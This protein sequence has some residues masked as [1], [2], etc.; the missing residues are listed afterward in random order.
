MNSRKDL[1]SELRAIQERLGAAQGKQYWRSLEEL[2][3]TPAFQELMQREFPDQASEWPDGLSRRQFLTLMGASLALAGLSGCSVRPAPQREIVPYVR[4]PEEMVPGKPLF[5]ATTMTLGG[6]ATG[7]LVES[8]MGRPTKVEGNPDHP[9]SRGATDVFA[10]ASVLTLYDPD[11]SQTV[12]LLG[13]TRTWDDAYTALRTALSKLENGAGLRVLTESVISPTLADQLGQLLDKYPEAR[14]H[15]HEPVDR[16]AARAGAQL[17]YGK[18]VD[19]HYDFNHADVILSLDDD[20]LGCGPG[21]LRYVADFMARRRVR[22]GTTDADRATMNRLYVVETSVTSTGAKADHRLA[23]R[24]GEIEAFARALAVELKVPGAPTAPRLSQAAL[25]WLRHVADDLR[26]LDPRPGQNRTQPRP[27]GTTLVV[28]GNRQPAAVHLLAHALNDYLGNVGKTVFHTA[29]VEVLERSKSLKDLEEDMREGKVKLLVILGGNPAYTTPADFSFVDLMSRV[30][31]RFH[32][33]LYQDETSRQCQWHLP[34]AHYLEA[35]SDARAYEGT[36][37]IVQPLIQPLY[38]GR[39]AHEV[40]SVL[41]QGRETPGYETVRAYWR[42]QL[43][44]RSQSTPFEELWQ[45]ALHDGVIAGTK[46]PSLPVSLR[47]G[48]A[49]DAVPAGPHRAGRR[50]IVFR[51]DPTLYDGR[52]ANNGWLQ[53]LPKPLTKLTWDNAALMSPKT[54]RELGVRELKTNSKGGP[55]GGTYTEVVEL[56]LHGWKVRAPVWIMPGHAD[57]SVTVYLGHGRKYAGRVGNGTGF[58]AY[59]LRPSDQLWFSSGLGVDRTRDTQLLACT[60]HHQLMENR[61]LVRS[62]TLKAYR[63]NPRFAAEP[64]EKLERQLTEVA[65]KPLDMYDGKE[66]NPSPAQRWAMA[67]DLTACTGC[68]A[69]VV[70]CQAENNIPVVGKDQVTRGREMHW[71]RIDTYHGSGHHEPEVPTE[72]HFQ[73]VPCMQCEAAPCEYVCPV[74]ATVHSADGLNDMVYNRCVGTRFCSNNCPYKVRRFNF[75]QFADYATESL[76]LMRNPDV[77]VRSR[78]VMEKCTYCVQRIRY[79]VI[80]AEKEERPVRDGEILTACQAACPAQA[81]LFGDLSHEDSAVARWK[82]SPLN[83]SLL[84]ELNTLPRTTYL[85]ALRNANPEMEA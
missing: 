76:K 61:A 79:A 32:L 22:T 52:F 11:R 20:F 55:H 46:F 2:A 25:S 19:T 3:D 24:A 59:A 4:A 69:C 16:E 60:Q 26:Y 72:F 9:A 48:W 35:W 13:R 30:P 82:K 77:T 66:P 73:P 63:K 44:A 15:R 58:N 42:K 64:E 27:R 80:E 75:F 65:R 68:S 36:A 83:Y 51:P 21:H 7:L 54:A 62:A 49:K 41:I 53:E 31:L 5:F 85:A 45:T 12:T 1:A 38:R 8:H 33:S 67:I 6:A 34:A 17:A 84:A 74:A 28:A 43:A 81:I 47:D 78:G 14:W 56:S 39:S 29:P 40:L 70:A 50:E 71:L 37:S 10:Q 57:G 18:D 23:L